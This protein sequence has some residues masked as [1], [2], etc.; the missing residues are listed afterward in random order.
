MLTQFQWL[1]SELS[2]ICKSLLRTKQLHAV[3]LK[4]H[5]SQDPF[6]ATKIVR[7]Y[8]ANNDIKSAYHMFDK[9]SNRSVYLWNSM[10]RA[11]AQSQRFANAFSL[12]RTMLGAD[13]SPDNYTYACVI[14]ACSDN[15]DFG[16]LRLV[17]GGAVASGLGLD[18]I[19]CSAL[20]TAYSKLG[21]VHEAHRVFNGI[22]E[23]DLV[24]WNSLIFGYGS[25]GVWDVGMEMFSSMR[26]VGKKPDEYTLAGLLMGIADPNLLSIG[27]G[28]HG[29]SQKS[30]LDCDSHVGSL[31]VSMY[32]RCNCMASAYSVFCS[33]FNPDLVTRSA[34]IAGYSQSG[35]YDK[36]LLFFRKL[37]MENKKADSVLIASVLSSIAQTANVA[38]GYEI[39]GYVLRHGLESDVKVSSA[40]IDMYSKCGFLRLGIYVFRIMPERNVISYNS[41]ILGLGLHGCTSEAFRMFVKMLEKGLVPDEATFTALL[42]ACCHAGLVKHGREIFRRMKDEFNIK[43]RPEHYVYMVKLLGSAGELEEAYNLT[44]SLPEP[45][46]KAILGALLSCCN[47]C[48]NSELAETVAQRLFESNPADNA[49]R[50]MLSNVYAGDGRWDDVKKLRDKIS[51]R[52]MPGLSWIEGSYC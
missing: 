39:H 45:V 19:C 22:P 23:P 26:L 5:L 42:C 40:L 2:N 46:D 11:F 25:S 43:A 13:I 10:I 9:T 50:V 8:A 6:Y 7:L 3:L 20:V 27:Q 16:M 30:G 31:L 52:K 24:L 41:V 32:S 17:H 21:L 44:Q 47:S 48:G 33:I 29:L 4:T 36:A 37:N 18:P 28:L 12:F 49:Y 1:H 38:L 34:L 14:R 15:F 51:L 35:E